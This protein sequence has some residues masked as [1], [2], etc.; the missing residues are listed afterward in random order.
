MQEL[1]EFT[2]KRRIPLI[3]QT[4]VAECGLACLAMISSYYGHRLDISSLRKLHVTGL[5]GMNFTQLISLAGDLGLACRAL[6]CP[7]EDVGKLQFPCIV[8][9]DLNHFVVI[10]S[11]SR[12]GVKVNDPAIGKRT[13]TL[14]K[15]G[16]HYT[17]I[18]LELT[19]TTSF[20]KRDSRTRMHLSQLWTKVVGFKSG[21]VSLLALSLVLQV[22]AVLNPYYMQLVVDEVLLSQDLPLLSVLAMGFCLLTIINTISTVIRSYLILRLSSMLN[23]QMGVNLLRHLLLLPMDYFEKRHIGDL[24]SRFGSLNQIREQL[25]TGVTEAIIDG[26]MSITIL[27]MM[28]IYSP[29]L[30]MIVIVTVVI[31]II[32]RLSLYPI[33]KQ[34]TDEVIQSGAKE[35]TNFLETIRGMQTIKLQCNEYMRQSLWQNQYAEL[36]NSE[37][38]LGKL[39]ISFKAANNFLFGIENVVVIYFAAQFAMDGFLTVGMLL[40]FM[41]YKVQFINHIVK[42][43]EQLI[44][45]GM[46]KL[47]LERISD[48]ALTEVESNR[49]SNAKAFEFKGEVRLDNVSF[50]YGEKHPWI[51]RNCNLIINPGESV[52]IVGSSGCGKST[53][54]KL[55]LGLLEPV[56]G[57]ILVDGQDIRQIGLVNYRKQI[58][59]VMQN[60][61][62]LTGSVLDNITFFDVEPNILKAQKAA[63]QAAVDVDIVTMQWDITH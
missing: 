19:P 41:A 57:R 25:T 33:L 51:V 36:I 11:I 58:A 37:I 55:M 1:L 12:K 21:V 24:V 59:A 31:Y 38:R 13:F 29:K 43:I 45:F 6:K 18:A 50:K 61:T 8:H 63:N 16:D 32:I 48:I 17:G 44:S 9:W 30:T 4:E 7:I 35:Q 53:L 20:K 49:E 22:V 26:F 56:E 3:M 28:L 62:L 34:H 47:H 60:D 39:D 46:V 23:M 5:G 27:I 10:T 2:G 40:A 54:M 52:A 15:F 14:K 42:F